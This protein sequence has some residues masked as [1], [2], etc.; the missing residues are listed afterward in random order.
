[1]KARRGPANEKQADDEHGKER[2]RND[3][4]SCRKGR[5]DHGRSERDRQDR[6]RRLEPGGVL[7]PVREATSRFVNGDPAPWGGYASWRDDATIVG[8]WGAYEEGW[9]G[10]GPR[11][12]RAA[13][14][15]SE[16]AEQRPRSSTCPPGPAE[17][18]LEP[19]R[20]SAARR[21][22]PMGTN[23]PRWRCESPA[24]FGRKP[25]S[26][27]SRTVTPIRSSARRR[28]PRSCGSD[29]GSGKV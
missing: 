27:S 9:N 2:E 17:T 22:W 19:W 11:Y 14:P 24:S 26:G 10:V 12:D 18:W 23:R 20:S 13:R 15:G 4:E 6:R 28:H 21:A 1:M 7:A 29:S 3:W 16:R 25:G 8:A 5:R